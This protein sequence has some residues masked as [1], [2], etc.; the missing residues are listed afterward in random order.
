[1][2]AIFING[3][4]RK[5]W[6]THHL[7]EKAAEGAR[8]SGAETE[9]IHLYDYSYKGCRSCF[10]CKVKG[11]TTQG[12][13]VIQDDLK[14][15]LQK[16]LDA[17]VLVIGSPVYHGSVTGEV[18]SFLERILF[19][20]MLYERDEAGNTVTQLAKKKRCGLILTMNASEKIMAEI[21]YQQHFSAIAASI[22][23]NI[24]SCEVLYACD[25]LQFQDYSNYHAS[26]FD[27]TAKKAHRSTQ[28]PLDLEN[29]FALGKKLC[30]G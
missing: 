1:M 26:M 2:K 7:L 20:A 28:F 16:I 27:E 18:H 24:G 15:V 29:A 23:R 13:C 4:P 19:P 12:L 21:G 10:A 14:P 9:L 22:R 11:N 8:S 5:N 30:N 25:T 3:S 17:D 6:N